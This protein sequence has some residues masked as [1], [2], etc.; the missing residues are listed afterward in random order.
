PEREMLQT[1]IDASQKYVTGTARVKLYKGACS[2]A[3]R[4]SPYSLYREDIATFEKDSVYQQADATGFIR[5]NSL[6]LRVQ[7]AAKR[8]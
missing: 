4:K 3:G 2:V 8:K 7:A 5:L 1:A 6:R